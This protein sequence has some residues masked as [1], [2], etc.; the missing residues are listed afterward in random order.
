MDNTFLK[1]YNEWGRK[2]AEHQGRVLELLACKK[3]LRGCGGDKKTISTIQTHIRQRE[4]LLHRELKL[5]HLLLKTF[6]GQLDNRIT[7]MEKDK[8]YLLST[9]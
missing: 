9:S 7:L 4:Q 2:M 8:P 1:D 5:L 3:M 6:E